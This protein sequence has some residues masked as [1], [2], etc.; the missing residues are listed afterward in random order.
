MFYKSLMVLAAVI[1]MFTITNCQDV[2]SQPKWNIKVASLVVDNCPASACACLTGGAPHHGTCRAVG[3]MHIT[4]GN[5]GDVSLT[6]QN[7]GMT[8]QFTSMDDIH[9]M[10]YYIDENASPEVK[11]ALREMLSNA[12]FGV[13]GEGFEIKETSIKYSNERGGIATF[14]LGEYG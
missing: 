13:I 5:Y 8:V 1:I 4:E 12:P 10:S 11:K 2:K 7:F 9:Y 6:G 14:S 3:V